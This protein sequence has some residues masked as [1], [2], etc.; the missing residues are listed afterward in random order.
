[1]E[2]KNLEKEI[3]LKIKN[4]N[5]IKLKIKKLNAVLE[6]R[7]SFEDNVLFDFPDNSLRKKGFALRI[8]KQGNE[9]YLTFKGEKIRSKNF[10]IREELEIKLEN[11]DILYDI[12][13]RIGLKKTFRYQKFRT[14][15]KISDVHV[16]LDETPVGNFIEIEGKEENIISMAEKLGYRDNDIITLDYVEIFKKTH[17]KGNMIFIK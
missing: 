11:P 15:F 17:K 8:R 9:A 5:Q 10:K 14:L 1:M 12:F 6:K 13:T 2:N 16:A 3:K 7:R 4:L